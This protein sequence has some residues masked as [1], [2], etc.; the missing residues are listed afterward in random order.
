M[1]GEQ[2]SSIA[3]ERLRSA[4]TCR[5]AE[6]AAD[7]LPVSLVHGLMD[8]V[9]SSLLV[10]DRTGRMLLMNQRRTAYLAFGRPWTTRKAWIFLRIF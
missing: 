2:L 1:S 8:A 7:A 5:F 10:G 4:D 6:R 3:A 9:N